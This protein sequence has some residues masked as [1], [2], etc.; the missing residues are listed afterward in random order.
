MQQGQ[1]ATS[2]RTAT[3]T[4]SWPTAAI[5]MIERALQLNGE[6]LE[7]VNDDVN[8]GPQINRNDCRVL[9]RQDGRAM[10]GGDIPV[11]GMVVDGIEIQLQLVYPGNDKPVEHMTLQTDM[12]LRYEDDDLETSDIRPIAT[13]TALEEDGIALR[14]FLARACTHIAPAA[15][16]VK[17]SA[18]ARVSESKTSRET[19]NERRP[20]A[21]EEIAA[22][23]TPLSQDHSERCEI[24]EAT[25]APGAITIA[26]PGWGTWGYLR[27]LEPGE[28]EQYRLP[29]GVEAT[30]SWTDGSE[31][32][33]ESDVQLLGRADAER[34]EI[35]CTGAIIDRILNHYRRTGGGDDGHPAYA[36]HTLVERRRRAA[37]QDTE[38]RK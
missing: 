4:G 16:G 28:R 25:S 13:R 36:L 11:E 19:E 26:E 15:R 29:A 38:R 5:A 24:Y 10:Y 31:D 12:A 8:D 2:R 9:Y 34:L 33:A 30:L 37:A 18:L 27:R 20:F 21:I 32:G 35:E 14:G 23:G 3:L 6:P 22:C 17:A 1:A 7:L